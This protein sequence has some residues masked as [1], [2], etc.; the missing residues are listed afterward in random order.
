MIKSVANLLAIGA[1]ALMTIGCATASAHHESGRHTASGQAYY[2]YAKV[3]DVEP[4]VTRRYVSTPREECHVEH[5][6]YYREVRHQPNHGGAPM[7]LGSLIGGVIGHQ[8]GDGNARKVSTVAGALIG[9]SIAHHAAHERHRS[10]STY[11]YVP[12]TERHCTM[13]ED[14]TEVEH[15]DGYNVTYRYQG[16]T[17]VK[18]TDT[19][20]GNFLIDE[21]GRA[22]TAALL[23]CACASSA[24]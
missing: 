24:W 22:I 15:V 11:N 1:T 3:I 9:G 17:F 5:G 6:G 12:R 8:F 20:P 19:H 10:R 7:L 18:R 4:I 13:V 16:Q 14:V 23:V 2:D 21:R